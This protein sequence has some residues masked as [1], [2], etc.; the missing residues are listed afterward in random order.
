MTKYIKSCFTKRII[1]YIYSNAVICLFLAL[2]LSVGVLTGC[3]GGGSS[4]SDSDGPTNGIDST[5]SLNRD[6]IMLDGEQS[7]LI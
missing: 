5:E 6:S 4:D 7:T 3:G 2:I 1:K